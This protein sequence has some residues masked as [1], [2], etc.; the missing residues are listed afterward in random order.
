MARAQ[1][2]VDDLLARTQSSMLGLSDAAGVQQRSTTAA[3]AIERWLE[4]FDGESGTNDR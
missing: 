1:L 2:P 4:S 3:E